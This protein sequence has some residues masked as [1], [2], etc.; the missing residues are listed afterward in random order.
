MEDA[1]L[2]SCTIEDGAVV[3]AGAKIGR[4]AVIEKG[5][6]VAAG[7]IVGEGVRVPSNQV[8][9]GHPAKYLRD[10]TAVER[11]NIRERHGEH[12]KLAEV[13]YESSS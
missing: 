4:G 5:A 13:H 6:M 11:D 10:I 12:L 1:T 7:A 9:A 2:N 8:W 3:G